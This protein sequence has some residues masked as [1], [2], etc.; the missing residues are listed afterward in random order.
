MNPQLSKFKTLGLIIVANRC[1]KKLNL[2]IPRIISSAAKALGTSRKTGYQ[3]A[4]QIEEVLMQDSVEKQRFETLERE[5]LLLR[6]QNQ[7]L[8]YQVKQPDVQFSEENKHLPNAAKSLCVRILRNFK[9]KLPLSHIAKAI[10]V[11]DSS[12]SRWNMDANKGCRFPAKPDRR[13]RHR[14]A[15]PQDANQVVKV[16]QDLKENMTLEAFTQH[17]NILYPNRKLDRKIITRILRAAG[18][19][20]I[21]PKSKRKDYH[22]KIKVY[23]PGAQIGIDAKKTTVSF[24]GKSEESITLTNEVAV[25][26]ATGAI[27][28]DALRKNEDAEGVK[29]VVI[30]ARKE[31]EKLLA[32][33]AD[34]RSSNTASE[35]Q[36]TMEENSELGPVFTFPYHAHTNG[37][38]EGLFGQ[39]SRTVGAIE[40]DDTSRESIAES[41]HELVWR[42]FSHF[43]NYAPC[44]ALDFK[45]RMDYLRTYIV[46]PQEL[47]EARQGL[48][49]Q[50][51]KSRK[52]RGPHSRLSNPVFCKQVTRIL[53]EHQ[54]GVEKN[55][56]L[57]ILVHYDLN[58]IEN[59]SVAF[60]A[61]S[62]RDGFDERK[63]HFA[64][65][66]GI[67]KNKQKEVDKARLE[68]AGE[69]LRTK[70][71][72]DE[73]AAHNHKVEQEKR[74]EKMDLKTKPD[75]I[76][77][78]YADLLMRGRFRYL[79]KTC[80]EKI[81]EGLRSLIRL[82]D[83][84]CQILENLSFA[85]RS[86]PDFT[87]D[88]KEKMIELLSEEIEQFID[89]VI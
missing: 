41:V 70:R 67:V 39:F 72:L 78:R 12:L 86:L 17:Y 79:R 87:E 73:N 83:T 47:A 18:L 8:T 88:R 77:L 13:G 30:K 80:F 85:I 6:I 32:I 4:A 45:S 7:V 76:I 57:E 53:R 48:K 52:S 20:Q 42:I 36:Q 9:E 84:A 54:F 14:H 35:A 61:Y 5:N 89:K 74:Q 60:S 82:G 26:M 25:D 64:Y 55:K 50:Q 34:N 28:G 71:L 29:T 68:S 63:R 43:R 51:T 23:F 66:M 58:I 22:G 10:G 69:I 24:T 56:A 40:I 19:Y 38:V 46:L 37:H 3:A 49:T 62:K 31:C 11:S 27:L 2:P 44:A 33:L 21:E 59:A 65:F 16:F 1:L 15:T 81:R 75:K